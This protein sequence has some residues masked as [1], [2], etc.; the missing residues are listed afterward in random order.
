MVA[1]LERIK[2][3]LE[4]E[5]GKVASLNCWAQA[6]GVSERVLKQH[7]AFGWHCREELIKSTRPLVLFLARNY[8]GLGIPFSDLLQVSRHALAFIDSCCALHTNSF[9][10]IFFFKCMRSFKIE[11][12]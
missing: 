2:T 6:A 11:A 4:K 1:N 5:S 8:R 3:T 12:A 10:L 7:L 9:K